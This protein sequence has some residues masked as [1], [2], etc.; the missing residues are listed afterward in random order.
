M[1]I[2]APRT[3]WWPQQL[4]LGWLNLALTAPLI[5]LYIGLPL[6]MRQNGWSGTQIGLM[7]LAGLPA[8][9]KFL[10]AT[11]VD[12]YRLGR[13]SYRNWSLVLVLGYAGALWL[14]AA[15]DLGNTEP[16]LMFLLAMLV[17]V[18]GT[19]ADVPLNALAIQI[20]PESERVRAGAIRSA[21]MSLG[22][23]VGGG[24]MLL[25][26]TRAGW[27][28]PFYVLGLGLLSGAVLLPWLKPGVGQPEAPSLA[29]PEPLPVQAGWRQWPGYFAVAE[30]RAWGL[31]VLLY[32][33]FLGAVWLYLKPLML[34][35]GFAADRIALI[36]GIVGGLVGALSSMLAGRLTRLIGAS[37]SLP[38]LALGNLLAIGFLT[39]VLL[40]GLGHNALIVAAM[41][42][43]LAMG[44]SAGL[45][46][47][48]MMYHT[49][50]GLAALDYGIQSSLFVATR[51]LVPILAGVLLDRLG[52]AGML[53]CLLAGLSLVLL[54]AW[55]SRKRI[56]SLDRP[57]HQ[58]GQLQGS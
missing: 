32:Y 47:G 8:M 57:S 31:L 37:I 4:L 6:V 40:A 52:Y 25:L 10:L 21:A 27:A 14:L 39:L 30:H 19:W 11:P 2:P 18:L 41:L 43:A 13:A 53:S 9:F 51:T 5:Y 22:A 45:M 48:L 29:R 33:P 28:W 54:L 44:A 35:Q 3:S 49:R 1:P 23:I 15:H 26:H 24:V 36:V 7:Q 16:R 34:D 55:H 46:F 20:L 56:F 42:V 17:S 38:L 12:R 50:P 58:P